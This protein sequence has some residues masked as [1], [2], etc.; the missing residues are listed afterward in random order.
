MR[1]GDVLTTPKPFAD[2][3]GG[4]EEEYSVDQDHRRPGHTSTAVRYL[5]KQGQPKPQRDATHIPHEDP[6]H[7]K[8]MGYE[9]GSGSAHHGGDK[10]SRP[11]TCPKEHDREASRSDNGLARSETVDTVHEVEKIAVSNDKKHCQCHAKRMWQL[12]GQTRYVQ[13]SDWKAESRHG[14]QGSGHLDR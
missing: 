3:E 14:R 5:R 6:R 11:A 9:S 1:T 4:I 12:D 8:V 13:C 10:C 7:R 2:C